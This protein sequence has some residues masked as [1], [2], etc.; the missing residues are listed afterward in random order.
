MPRVGRLLLRVALVSLFAAPC[1]GLAP[2]GSPRL[3]RADALPGDPDDIYF[4][5]TPAEQCPTGSEMCPATIGPAGQRPVEAKC[6]EA[7]TAKKLER[8]CWG[9][10]GHLYCPAGATGSWTG[11]VKQPPPPSSQQPSQ[12]PSQPASSQPK[13]GCS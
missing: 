5:C 2:L 1:V 7:A 11:K 12:P 8:R 9:K 3:A 13:R 10:A 6:A 4:H